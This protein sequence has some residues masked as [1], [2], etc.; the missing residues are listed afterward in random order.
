MCVWEGG[1]IMCGNC[2]VN[3]MNRCLSIMCGEGNA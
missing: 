1:G 2:G 3:S